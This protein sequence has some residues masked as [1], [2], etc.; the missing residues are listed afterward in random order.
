M[1]QGKAG[2]GAPS[3]GKKPFFALFAAVFIL[4]S[5]SPNFAAAQGPE[6]VRVGYLPILAMTPIYLAVENGYFQAEG[7]QVHLVQFASGGKMVTPLA[8]GMIDAGSG[9]LSAGLFN[10]IAQ[11]M[12]FKIVAATT[13]VQPGHG[14]LALVVRQDL[15]DSGAVQ[16]WQDLK[17]RT[18]GNYAKGILGSY[19]IAMIFAQK[20]VSYAESRIV[21]LSPP[22]VVAALAN[23][24]VD[25][26]VTVE[27]W[28]AE[29]ELKGFARR[30]VTA[31]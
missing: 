7:L 20:G 26:G 19:F 27:P 21:Y 2:S 24:A 18:L 23:K 8:T 17:D 22:N 30:F 11:G 4:I 25:A 31:D 15:L 28:A 14:A 10:S 29:E 13:E 12:E 16:N 5:G 1:P 3:A 9:S 6:E